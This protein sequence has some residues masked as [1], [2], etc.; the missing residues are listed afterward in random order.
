M[1]TQPAWL[2]STCCGRSSSSFSSDSDKR[3]SIGGT[4]L[5][6]VNRVLRSINNEDASLCVDI[7]LR[8]DGTVGFEEFRRDIEDN[9]G[10]FPVGGHSFR[11]FDDEGHALQAAKADVSWLDRI[12]GD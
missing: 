4:A 12:L 7:F 8:P 5:A 3:A 1:Q 11:V 6:H 10:W 2:A 9:R